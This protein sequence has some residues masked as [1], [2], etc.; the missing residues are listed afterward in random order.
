MKLYV[1][2]LF[3]VF[4]IELAL[5]IPQRCDGPFSELTEQKRTVVESTVLDLMTTQSGAQPS[6]PQKMEIIIDTHESEI[7]KAIVMKI[8]SHE[9]VSKSLHPLYIDEIIMTLG[10]RMEIPGNVGDSMQ[11]ILFE[12][13]KEKNSTIIPSIKKYII[14]AFEY[15]HPSLSNQ[16]QSKLLQL[17][18]FEDTKPKVKAKIISVLK[19]IEHPSD[20]V[21]QLMTRILEKDSSIILR[22][23]ALN[24]FENQGELPSKIMNT[25]KNS[26]KLED[27]TL[28]L[29]YQK[30]QDPFT[31]KRMIKYITDTYESE[32]AEVI[33]LKA[34]LQSVHHFQIEQFQVELIKA[35]AN[36]EVLDIYTQLTLMKMLNDQFVSEFVKKHL[37]K[38]LKM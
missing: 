33:F 10:S 18:N 29:E 37:S 16:T 20:E 5:A 30:T 9:A 3:S 17:F 38:L 23:H 4:T 2:I 19:G 7:V 11:S 13:L 31:R 6:L 35:L 27:I 12:V 36:L 21:I 24:F 14:H 26:Q 28:L 8:L 34:L 22:R 15:V 32:K 1:L 25:L